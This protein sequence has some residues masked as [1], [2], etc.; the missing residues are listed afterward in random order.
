MLSPEQYRIVMGAAGVLAIV[1]LAGLV[2]IFRRQRSKSGRCMYRRMVSC[3]GD[4]VPQHDQA[5][6]NRPAPAGAGATWGSRSAAG[7]RWTPAAQEL[8]SL[9]LDYASTAQMTD[10]SRWASRTALKETGSARAVFVTGMH[11]NMLNG[12]LLPV[13]MTGSSRWASRTA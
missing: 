11:L 5:V 6:S 9:Q 7:L 1:A 13:Q 12:V 3:S 2:N 10:S 8:Q 4:V